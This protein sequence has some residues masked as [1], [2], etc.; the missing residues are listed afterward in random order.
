MFLKNKNLTLCGMRIIN[1]VML[2]YCDVLLK[3][4]RSTMESRKDVELVRTFSFYHSPKKWTGVPIMTANMAS[5]GTFSTAIVLA[6]HKIITTFH[7][8]YSIEEYKEFFLTF[9]DPDYVSYTL[10]IRDRDV[11]QL[12]LMIKEKL[13]DNFSFGGVKYV[14]LEVE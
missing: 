1:E 3:P 7:K 4:K 14:I 12:K 9:K 8:Y 13:I 5:C 2:D 10:G 11:E 6:K